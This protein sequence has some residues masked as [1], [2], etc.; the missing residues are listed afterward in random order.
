M[1]NNNLSDYKIPRPQDIPEEHSVII[2]EN[3]LL[4]GPFGARGMGEL[5]LI[6][7]AAAIGNAVRDA[8][9]VEMKE[10]PLSPERIWRALREKE[11]G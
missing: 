2:I 3:P 7:L 4:S 8:V 5:C 9:G 11:G 6:S 10:L 1:L